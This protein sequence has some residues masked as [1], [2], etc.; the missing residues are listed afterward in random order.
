M[1]E[2][3]EALAQQ[4]MDLSRIIENR[5]RA[6]MNARFDAE[7]ADDAQYQKGYADGLHA[8][9]NILTDEIPRIYKDGGRAE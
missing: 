5:E 3:R 7:T 2:L 6:A 4:I 9:W 8:A 1:D